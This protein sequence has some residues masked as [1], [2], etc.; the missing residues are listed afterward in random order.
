MESGGNPGGSPGHA[1]SLNVNSKKPVKVDLDLEVSLHQLT[2]ELMLEGLQ[3]DLYST[4]SSVKL[5]S[6]EWIKVDLELNLDLEDF[7]ASAPGWADEGEPPDRALVLQGRS[8][9]L[10]NLYSQYQLH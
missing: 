8:P 5:N 9:N 10:S 6:K 4:F 7:L 2:Q 3:I 1:A